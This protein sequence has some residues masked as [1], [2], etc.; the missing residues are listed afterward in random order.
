VV[1]PGVVEGLTTRRLL[2]M[3]FVEGAKVTDVDG[4][5]RAGME[6]REVAVLLND[7]YAE[8][9][10]ERGVLHADPHPGNLL[11]QAGR[12]GPR[13]VLL[14]HGLT[15]GLDP[16]FVAAL[17]RLVRA[18]GDGDLEGISAS[19]GEAGLPVG[20]DT[21]LDVLLAVVGVLLGGERQGSS[22]V[23]LG[24]FGLELG[25]SVGD[26]PPK[27]LLIGR[28]IGLL[29]GITRQ[30]DPDLDALEIVCRHVPYAPDGPTS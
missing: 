4:L 21:N 1:V 17:G 8:Q 13:L 25:A 14:D 27:L 2:V 22:G 28:A 18:L 9:L 7:A 3:E 29:D 11:V 19:L 16:A 10:F 12:E 6:P 23:D 20:E 26:I 5:K 30:L 15:L 24:G